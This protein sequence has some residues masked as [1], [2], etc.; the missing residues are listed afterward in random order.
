MKA[1]AVV[2]AIG[3]CLAVGAAGQELNCQVTVTHSPA[4][5]VGAVEK[6]VFAELK[7]A[8]YDFMNNT[9]WTKDLFEV[10]ERIDMSILVT[11]DG[12][13]SSSVYSGKIQVQVTRP[14]FNTS[15]NSVLLNH[16]DNDFRISY[17]RNTVL[18]FSIDR[19]RDELTSVL[20][21]Y[22]YMVLGYDYD[23]FSLEGGTPYFNKAQTVVN[24]A[25]NAGGPGW[26][27]KGK[28]NSRH[29]MVDNALQSVF[30]PMRKVYYDYHRNGLDKMYNDLEGGRSTILKTVEVLETV[31]RSRPGS[32]NMQM[33]LTAKSQELIDLFSQS[34]MK[35]KNKV[36]NLLKRLDPVNASKYQQILN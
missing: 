17:A 21:F 23:S 35:E 33:F 6:E 15:Y 29:W 7:T 19:Y 12:N 18:L 20:A 31:G 11:I 34:E 8:I 25:R 5:T 32:L 2:W 26:Q 16:V 13:P 30:K 14:V 4:F 3:W 9:R 22:A 28:R 36:V 27:A 24:N 1:K 10:E